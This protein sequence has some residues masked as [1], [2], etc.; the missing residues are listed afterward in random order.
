MDCCN[1]FEVF[2][3]ENN[4]I[5]EYTH[6]K[7][8]VRNRNS[9]LGNCVVVIKRHLESFSEATPEEMAEF[10]QVVKDIEGALK[11]LFNYDKMN[12]LMLMMKD[13]HVHFHVL[14]RYSEVKEFYGLQWED[15]AWPSMTKIFSEKKEPLTQEMLNKIKEEIKKNI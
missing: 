5:K 2:D 13:K 12:W 8:L 4:L 6:W 14:P 1:I 9:T 7:L 10:A 15:H 11:K 3:E